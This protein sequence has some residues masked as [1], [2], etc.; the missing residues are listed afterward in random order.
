LIF[1]WLFLDTIPGIIIRPRLIKQIGNI[2]PIIFLVSFTAPLF[3]IGA[4]GII[5]GPAVFGFL[6]GRKCWSGMERVVDG[7]YIAR[8]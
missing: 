1:G 4:M 8:L 2:H 6:L 5:I 7:I 3:M